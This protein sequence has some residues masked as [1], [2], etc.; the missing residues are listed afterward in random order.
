MKKSLFFSLLIVCTAI[1]TLVAQQEPR[2]T[3]YMYNGLLHNPAYAGRSERLSLDA[4][5]R[6]QWVKIDGAPKEI[7]ISGHAA[8]TKKSRFGVGGYLEYDQIGVHQRFTLGGAYSYR[9][10]V[11]PGTLSMGVEANILHLRSNWSDVQVNP[12]GN[13]DDPLFQG[14]QT[15]WLPNFGLGLYF[16][17]QAFYLG[18]S[19]PRLLQNQ[20]YA[21]G[22]V[23]NAKEFRNYFFTVGGVIQPMED[24]ALKPSALVKMVPGNAP[25]Q[26]D[27]NLNLIIRKMFE[28]GGS[29]RF[30]SQFAPESAN[31]IALFHYKDK[32]R[33]GYAYDF[34]ISQLQSYTAGSHEIM[35]GMDI[36]GTKN[37]YKSPRYF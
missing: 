35:L 32:Y 8:L 16:N 13:D 11:G 6:N 34:T 7:A 2:Y 27:L 23:G 14:D 37:R 15:A 20:L 26:T 30:D 10:Q 3:M 17:T 33:I 24:F 36:G 1:Q 18:A 21:D 9:L 4:Y 5:Y 28:M 25:I 22:T 29:F 19:C 31:L 12:E